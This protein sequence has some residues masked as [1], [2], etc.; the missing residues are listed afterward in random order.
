MLYHYL[1]RKLL[2]RNHA[3]PI[4]ISHLIQS[5]IVS[6][7]VIRISRTYYLLPKY[8]GILSLYR[9]CEINDTN[10]DS[11]A[12][13]TITNINIDIITTNTIISI[14]SIDVSWDCSLFSPRPINYHM[15]A[16]CR[17]KVQFRYLHASPAK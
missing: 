5:C 12:A 2:P 15:Q 10:A 8:K 17:A 16:H 3:R 1:L 4:S 6:Y 13:T 11:I 9:S 14:D 7:P